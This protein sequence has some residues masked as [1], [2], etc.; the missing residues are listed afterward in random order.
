MDARQLTYFL[1][2]VDHGGFNRAAEHLFIAQPSVSQSIAR[3]ESELGVQLFHRIGRQVRVSEAGQALIGPA[4]MVLRGLETARSSVDEV[5]GVRRGRLDISSMPSPGIAPL[6]TLAAAFLSDHP[7]VTLNVEAAFTVDGVIQAVRTGVCEIGLAGGREPLR[8]PDVDVMQIEQQPII[9]IV[10]PQADTFG[11]VEHVH[12]K[13]L[14][15]HR[16][17]VSQ[18]GSL[19]RWVIDD[20]LAAGVDAHI[21]LEV[22]HRTSILPMVL[23]GLG[24]AVM[25][26]AWR[27]LAQSSG[28][29][30]LTV[31]PVSSLHV[32]ILSRP[33]SLTPT[34]EAFLTSAAELLDPRHEG[35]TERQR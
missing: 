20:I 5:R 35:P 10:N 17:I 4:R 30:T 28:L 1:A 21:A 16:F 8:V 7:G 13:D 9:L 14:E 11:A 18:R 2:V 15:G 12:R 31:E 32:A 24:H 26:S 6:T 25:P 29:R 23:A 3:L 27:S 33:N 19:M 34:A 22:A